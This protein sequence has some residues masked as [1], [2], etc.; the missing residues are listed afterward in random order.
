M[1]DLRAGVRVREYDITAYV[2]NVGD[3]R[4]ISSLSPETI[5]GV[6]AERAFIQ[7][8]R[9]VGVTLAGKF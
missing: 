9:T 4:A 3:V 7:T 8:P 5:N 2:K 1:V 6:A